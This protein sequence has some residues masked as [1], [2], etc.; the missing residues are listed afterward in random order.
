MYRRSLSARIFGRL[1]PED[2]MSRAWVDARGTLATDVFQAV[3]AIRVVA[4][5]LLIPTRMR[6]AYIKGIIAFVVALA[7]VSGGQ[8][9]SK[10]PVT[11]DNVTVPI[12]K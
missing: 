12:A 1:A 5:F 8:V 4:V 2:V 6:P 7:N 10:T 3:A 11:R 9:G